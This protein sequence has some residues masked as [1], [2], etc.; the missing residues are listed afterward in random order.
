MTKTNAELSAK[1]KEHIL[2]ATKRRGKIT[3]KAYAYISV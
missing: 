1:Q 2:R 3:I